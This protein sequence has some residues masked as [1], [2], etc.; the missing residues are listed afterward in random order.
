MSEDPVQEGVLAQL[1]EV[2]HAVAALGRERTKEGLLEAIC[3]ELAALVAGRACVVSRVERDTLYEVAACWPDDADPRSTYPGYAYLLEDYPL[4]RAVL[5]T[6]RPR[7]V[8]LSDDGVEPSEAFVLRELA[9]HAVLMVA[10]GTNDGAWGLIEVYDD[11]PR[12]FTSGEATLAELFARQAAGLLAQIENAEA[13]QRLYR[14]TLAS[15]VNA[16]GHKDEVTSKH[17][18]EVVDLAVA[19]ASE[20]GVSGDDLRRIELGALLHD[21]GKIRIPETLLTKPGPLEEREWRI[22]RQ[23]TEA[24]EAILAPIASL[25][26]ILPVVRS[27]HE[28]WDGRGYPDGLAG[29][30]IPLGARV[31]A[32]CDAFHA[33]TEGRPYR[34]A[35]SREGA[36]RELRANAGRQFDPTCVDALL[37]VLAAQ[38]H[39]EPPLHRPV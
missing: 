5:D 1:S 14:E 15:L 16:L 12:R 34:P 27:S 25:R 30:D 3:R 11:R 24:G 17:A 23:H 4:T 10:L 21:I 36:E 9:M 6:G 8:S 18:H 35:M 22:M 32:V 39:E 28:R 33:L 26:D 37:A 38:D 19:V 2:A 13:V 31:V 7:G 20:L 29:E